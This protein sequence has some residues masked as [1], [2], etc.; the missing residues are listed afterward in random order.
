MPLDRIPLWVKQGAV[1]PLA[2]EM[3]YVTQKSWDPI[4][5]DIYPDPGVLNGATLYEDDTTT[6]G[7]Q[8]GQFRTTEVTATTTQGAMK[9]VRV[10]IYRTRGDFAKSIQ[11]RS[12]KLRIHVPSNW[13]KNLMGAETAI[14]GRRISDQ[15]STPLR[16]KSE[17]AMPFGDISGAPDRD[18]F[19]MTLPPAPVMEKQSVEI[20]FQ[21][22]Q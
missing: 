22:K 14:N 13:P 7:Y 6:T 9:I 10:D 3:D 12:W 4:T 21:P 2:P 1:L 17:K 16:A 8:H 15:I 18:V 11:M 19:E 20:S 5:L